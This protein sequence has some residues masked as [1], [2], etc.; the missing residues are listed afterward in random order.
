M[1]HGLFREIDPAQHASNLFH[2]FAAVQCGHRGMGF[3]LPA[4]LMDE[5]VVVPLGGDLGQMGH[6]QYLAALA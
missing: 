3:I 6:G 2:A 4:R 1:R 5:Q